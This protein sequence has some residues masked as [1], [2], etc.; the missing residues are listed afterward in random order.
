VRQAWAGLAA[1]TTGISRELADA[2]RVLSQT[3]RDPELVRRGHAGHLM[4]GALGAGVETARG[5]VD[6]FNSD[7]L[8]APTD[9]VV[10]LTRDVLARTPDTDAYEVW[11]GMT[12]HAGRAPIALPD[13]LRDDLTRTALRNVE[14]ATTLQSASHG[15]LDTSTHIPPTVHRVRSPGV[16][17]ADRAVTIRPRYPVGPRR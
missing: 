10:T 2:A 9:V 16:D 17:A 11:M 8:R 4:A 15:L 3:L 13:P 14:A 12:R 6:A 7:R 5:L 1:P